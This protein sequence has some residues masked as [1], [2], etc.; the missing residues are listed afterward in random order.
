VLDTPQK[1]D[2]GPENQ[3][4][5]EIQ[6]SLEK[7]EVTKADVTENSVKYQ[8]MFQDAVIISELSPETIGPVATG[9]PMVDVSNL[10]IRPLERKFVGDCF[11]DFGPLGLEH[12]DDHFCVGQ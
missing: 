5:D 3:E 8:H 9:L 7:T 2:V 6:H 4:P 1:G 10:H 12:L 11:C